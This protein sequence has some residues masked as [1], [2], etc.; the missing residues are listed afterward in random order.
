M[1]STKST[2]IVSM[3]LWSSTNHPPH[4][5]VTVSRRRSCHQ[6]LIVIRNNFLFASQLQNTRWMD[7]NIDNH[8]PVSYSSSSRLMRSPSITW[9]QTLNYP[10]DG[11]RITRISFSHFKILFMDHFA[12]LSPFLNHLRIL[13][14]PRQLQS[15]L[16][17]TTRDDGTRQLSRHRNY[18]VD[19]K[20]SGHGPLKSS[21]T[22]SRSRPGHS[23]QYQPSA[24]CE[25]WSLS[26]S[27]FSH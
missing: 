12:G 2:S 1:S 23:Q 4:S 9:P 18:I 17:L 22:V 19:Q 8:S 13:P 3:R 16:F 6:K 20:K 7:M 15:S 24:R 10:E 11:K 26:L 25:F 5:V 14:R 27:A 21:A